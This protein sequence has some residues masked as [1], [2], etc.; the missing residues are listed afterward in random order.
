MNRLSATS[1]PRARHVIAW[2]GA[3]PTSAGPG[4]PPP[5][6]QGL[7]GRDRVCTAHV[8]PLQ[9]GEIHLGTITWGFTPGC[10]ITGFQPCKQRRIPV[11]PLALQQ[12]FV[13]RVTEIRAMQS[14]QAASRLRLESL[15]QSLLHRALNGEL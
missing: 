10:H 7:K 5:K 8:P 12:E 11:S 4:K 14:D 13:V 1:G 3:S 9:G 15:F 2:A 6:I